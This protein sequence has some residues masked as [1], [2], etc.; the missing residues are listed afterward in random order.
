[1]PL[2]RK[3]K[4]STHHRLAHEKRRPLDAGDRVVEPARLLVLR[5]HLRGDE[6]GCRGSRVLE[7]CWFGG[8][9][10]RKRR[11]REEGEEDEG[12]RLMEGEQKRFLLSR[13]R[14]PTHHFAGESAVV[15]VLSVC[16]EDE[17]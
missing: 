3:N 15:D 8:G 4:N 9:E 2:K 13:C 17:S 11:K 16:R 7:G 1:M 6:R 12:H 14:G 10:K 5:L